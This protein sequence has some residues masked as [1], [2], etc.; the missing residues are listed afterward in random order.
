MTSTLN[1]NIISHLELE[2]KEMKNNPHVL[3][4]AMNS[5]FIMFPCIRFWKKKKKLWK[6]KQWSLEGT[7][8]T[9][10]SKPLLYKWRD[11]AITLS[12]INYFFPRFIYQ[13]LDLLM[14]R[15][16]K[17]CSPW[18]PLVSM[19]NNYCFFSDQLCLQ[20]L[21]GFSHTWA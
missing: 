9:S 15:E 8:T 1:K 17:Q 19:H 10:N 2:L 13:V 14:F 18:H 21:P 6:L 16:K 20:V 11:G 7:S 5:V 3:H 4:S 12:Y